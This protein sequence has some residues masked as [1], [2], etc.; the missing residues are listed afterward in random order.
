MKNMARRTGM[1]KPMNIPT[2]KLTA[3][4]HIH[5]AD[6]HRGLLECATDLNIRCYLDSRVVEV[7]PE[8]P[9]LVT[10][11]G[12]RFTSDLVIA[13][14]GLHSMCRH[15]IAGRPSLPVP[16]GQMVYRVTVAAKK[17]EGIP[18]LEEIITVPRNNHWIGPHGTILSYLLEGIDE[19]L[20]N[21]VL[22]C[23][24]N[25]AFTRLFSC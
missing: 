8:I 14:D 16:T 2:I 5:R 15:I 12:K 25:R 6:F 19:M 24:H 13:S 11:D 20:V 21:L 9:A 1:L 17:L 23:V 18:E 4:R 22:T 3:C 7:D 10:V